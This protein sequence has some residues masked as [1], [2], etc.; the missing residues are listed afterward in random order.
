MMCQFCNKTVWC[1]KILSNTMMLKTWIIVHVVTVEKYDNNYDGGDNDN[2]DDDDKEKVEDD[3]DDCDEA[4][5]SW[6]G[7]LFVPV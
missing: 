5:N 3:D 6:A 1:L 4:G 2:E 7:L